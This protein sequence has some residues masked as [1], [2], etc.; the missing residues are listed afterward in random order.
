MQIALFDFD[1]TLIKEN[2]LTTLFKEVAGKKVLF[3]E[4]LTL[5][6]KPDTYKI[7]IKFSIKKRLYQRCIS[8][9]SENALFSAGK[10]AAIKLNPIAEVSKKLHQLQ[11][12]NCK[13]W[14]VTATPT[15][16]VKGI[17]SIWNWPVTQIIG[18]E[19]D[20][21][22]SVYTGE[23]SKECIQEE[24]KRRILE[25]IAKEKQQT[26]IKVAYGNLP[27][28]IPMLKLAL[29][30]YIVKNQ[31]IFVWNRFSGKK[32]QLTSRLPDN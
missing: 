31:Q 29:K 6:F 14:I 26:F 23:F 2:S 18:T 1:E 13:I 12:Q 3:P 20:K 15:L 9:V 10:V 24:K 19:L 28:D 4:L 7:G 27:V 17:I 22:C 5:A 11:Q 32:S 25:L 30:S 8:G 16:F 21:Y